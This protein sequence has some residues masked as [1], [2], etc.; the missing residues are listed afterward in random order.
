MDK[1]QQRCKDGQQ[2]RCNEWGGTSPTFHE[3]KHEKLDRWNYPENTQV[4]RSDVWS[5][6]HTDMLKLQEP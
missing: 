1:Q 5:L 4:C 3:S 2:Q 6:A